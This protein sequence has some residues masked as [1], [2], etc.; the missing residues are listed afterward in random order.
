VNNKGKNNPA[1]R[2]GKPKCTD[3]GKQLSKYGAK[4]CVKH[5]NIHSLLKRLKNHK[6]MKGKSNPSYIDGRCSKNYYCKCGNSIQYDS[7]R[8]GVKQCQECYVLTLKGKTHPRWLGGKSFEPYSTEWTIKLKQL[9]RKR[10]SY[11]CTVCDKCGNIVHHIDYN[12]ENCSKKNLITLCNSCHPKTNTDRDYWYAYFT[13][14]ME[15]FK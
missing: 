4:R 6:S 10:D 12:K 9:I 1:W 11:K 2:G 8:K 13:Y 5:A 14:I 15:N 7:I 3:C